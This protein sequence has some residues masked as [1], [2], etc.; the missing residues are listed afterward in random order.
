MA[1]RFLA[2]LSTTVAAS[3]PT[4]YAGLAIAIK[5]SGPSSSALCVKDTVNV[6]WTMDDWIGGTAP[7]WLQ[8]LDSVQDR[9][10][11]R[12]DLFQPNFSRVPEVVSGPLENFPSV[13]YCLHD[14]PFK[15][16]DVRT[17]RY[18]TV[19]GEIQLLSFGN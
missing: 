11:T 6:S 19:S 2:L 8:V 1:R 9:E 18:S 13:I 5:S 17:V 12:F 4:V 14:G 10:V 15:I 7:V 16:P 3:L